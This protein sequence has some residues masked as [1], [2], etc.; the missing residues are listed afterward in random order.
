MSHVIGEVIGGVSMSSMERAD[1]KRPPQRAPSSSRSAWGI[2]TH[3]SRWE[4]LQLCAPLG[5][6]RSLGRESIGRQRPLCGSR[7]DNSLGR[8]GI[9]S[10]WSSKSVGSVA[11]WK[12]RH[13]HPLQQQRRQSGRGGCSSCANIISTVTA[14]AATAAV[15]IAHRRK[16]QD[17]ERGV[18]G[19]GCGTSRWCR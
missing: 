7:D 4:L 11:A 19:R 13:Q 12:R 9:N 14:A 3:H 16:S 1:A 2:A 18:R 15:A 6:E 10:R 17:L 8:Q 5:P